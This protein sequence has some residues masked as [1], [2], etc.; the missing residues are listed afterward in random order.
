MRIKTIKNLLYIVSSVMVMGLALVS[1]DAP[2]SGKQTV[3]LPTPAPTRSA[4]K[5]VSATPTP[6]STP[7]PTATPTPSLAQLNAELVI[8]PATDEIGNGLTT[9]ISNHL[10]KHYTDESYQVKEISNVFCHYKEGLADVDYIVYAS[11][12]VLYEGSNV[13]V[14]TLDEYLVCIDRENISVLSETNNAEINEALF[15]SRASE[16]VSKLYVKE[17]IR[18]YKNA[19][20]AVDEELLSSLVTDTSYLNLKNIRKET[21]YI[22]EYKNFDYLFFPAPEEISEYDC[23]VFVAENVKIVNISTLAPGGQE[24]Y[25]TL[26]ENNYPRIFLGETSAESDTFISQCRSSSEYQLFRETHVDKPFAEAVLSDPDLFEFIQRI[27][28]ATGTTE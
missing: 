8:R 3:N 17:L 11:Y 2:S 27:T 28:N 10:K 4:D 19:N 22:E 25:I 7:I 23:F 15:L 26:D 20:L 9:L 6:T 12:D 18:R 14:P 21:E 1:F 16:S 24:L 5:E 13:P